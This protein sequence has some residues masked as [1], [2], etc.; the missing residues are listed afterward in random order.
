MDM[1]APFP[2]LG[3]DTHCLLS[4]G[5]SF[6]DSGIYYDSLHLHKH[7]LPPTI[8]NGSLPFTSHA[9]RTGWN[10]SAPLVK[11]QCSHVQYWG[12]V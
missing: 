1:P 8:S 3:T 5:G 4:P 7:A 12:D 2:S 11:V 10:F 9:D 6:W